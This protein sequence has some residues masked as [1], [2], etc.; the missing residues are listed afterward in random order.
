MAVGPGRRG[1]ACNGVSF[2]AIFGQRWIP[3]QQCR[4]CEGP[5]SPKQC[6]HAPGVALTIPPEA[7]NR[8]CPQ[9]ARV[10]NAASKMTGIIVRGVTG[11]DSLRKHAA[12]SGRAR[13]NAVD[14]ARTLPRRTPGHPPRNNP[15]RGRH[16]RHRRR[17]RIASHRCVDRPRRHLPA[18]HHRRARSWSIRRTADRPSATRPRRGPCCRRRT[19]SPVRSARDPAACPARPTP[20]SVPNAHRSGSGRWRSSCRSRARSSTR[21]CARRSC[22]VQRRRASHPVERLIRAGTDLAAV[23]VDDHLVAN[24]DPPV[25]VQ[26]LAY[27]RVIDE[28]DERERKQ[29]AARRSAGRSRHSS[30]SPSRFRV[31]HLRACRP[32]APRPSP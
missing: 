8:K 32:D 21:R 5:V 9:A 23:F 25:G 27:L 10:A 11:R 14:R 31:T 15:R 20:T 19:P 16:R 2:S 26:R 12:V 3:R 1:G 6:R 4:Q 24:R 28:R 7:P 29:P 22:S 18:A 30:R 13:G 17:E